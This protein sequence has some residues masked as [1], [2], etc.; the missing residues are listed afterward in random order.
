MFDSEK[1]I[2]I[3]RSVER[4]ESYITDIHAVIQENKKQLENLQDEIMPDIV[5]RVEKESSEPLTITVE[6]NH[7][8][9]LELVNRNKI[10]TGVKDA[11]LE[12]LREVDTEEAE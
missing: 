4:L 6:F 5:A 3:Q 7:Q 2:D 9:L 8:E 11:V 1:I 12:A 10:S